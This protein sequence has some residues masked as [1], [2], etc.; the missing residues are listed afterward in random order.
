MGKEFQDIGGH[1]VLHNQWEVHIG[2]GHG[3]NL[4]TKT[5]VRNLDF[6]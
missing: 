1:G 4:D 5:R 3:L 6:V 2:R